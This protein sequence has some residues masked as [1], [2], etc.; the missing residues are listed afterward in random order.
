MCGEHRAGEILARQSVPRTSTRISA[1]QPTGVPIGGMPG[2]I[3]AGNWSASAGPIPD[4]VESVAK[5]FLELS[6]A[7]FIHT[8]CALVSPDLPEGVPHLPFGKYQTTSPATS[9]CSPNSSRNDHG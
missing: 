2:C 7:D 8:G 6:Q 5:I 3:R 1:K 4:L 9:S